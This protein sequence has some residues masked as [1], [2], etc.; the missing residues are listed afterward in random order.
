M[1]PVIPLHRIWTVSAVAFGLLASAG[2]N[3]KSPT[4]QEQQALAAKGA[5]GQTNPDW[6]AAPLS[7]APRYGTPNIGGIPDYTQ[8]VPP[9]DSSAAEVRPQEPDVQTVALIETAKPSDDTVMAPES[10]L[11]R[12]AKNCP[13]TDKSVNDALKTVDRAARIKKYETLTTSCP[14][15]SDLWT[16]LGKDYQAAGKLDPAKH[17][18]DQAVLLNPSN[19]DAKAG[20]AG[21]QR[22]IAESMRQK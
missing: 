4:Y 14:V 6:S 5:F 20:L 11:D 3:L 7:R 15:S 19:D 13:G 16:W 17:A 21:I 2:C 9:I 1:K 10:P 8:P 18:F 22:K 12:I